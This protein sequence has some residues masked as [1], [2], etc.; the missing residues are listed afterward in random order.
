[1]VAHLIPAPVRLEG[2]VE[3]LLVLPVVR[4]LLQGPAVGLQ[5]A[6]PVPHTSKPAQ[7]G[8]QLGQSQDM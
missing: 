1:M 7:R 2:V 5:H 3:D 6:P 8:L 4:P